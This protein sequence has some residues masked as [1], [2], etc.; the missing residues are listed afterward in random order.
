MREITGNPAAVDGREQKAAEPARFNFTVRRLVFFS[1]LLILTAAFSLSYLLRF[2]FRI[3]AADLSRMALQLPFAILIQFGALVLIGSHRFLWR[4]VGMLEMK[5][6][7]KAALFS[8]MLMLDIC[9]SIPVKVQVIPSLYEI[10]QG[11]CLTIYA[12]QH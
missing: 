2:D 7:S 3:T 1:D 9:K 6:F 11:S 8:A 12:A 4:Y 10:L 5:A